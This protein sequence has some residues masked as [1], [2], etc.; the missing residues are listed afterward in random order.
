M[1]VE[2]KEIQTEWILI[3][4]D[5]PQ[6]A[7]KLRK[8]ILR[9]ISELGGVMNTASV[10]LLPYSENVMELANQISSDGD[11]VIW[12]SKQEH[13]EIAKTITMKYQE[14]LQKRCSAIQLRL[15]IIADHISKEN[16]GKA[17]RMAL[18]TKHL[19][20]QLKQIDANYQTSWLA[21]Q[22]GILEISLKEVYN[23]P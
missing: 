16:L 7:G 9:R 15:A 3:C 12:K 1:G 6:S 22:I 19:L 17:N 5:I 4:F 10:Y 11:V 2:I 18:K 20:D 8:L 14:H 13:P 23:K 21:K